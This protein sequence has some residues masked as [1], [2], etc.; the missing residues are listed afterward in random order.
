MDKLLENIPASDRVL[1]VDDETRLRELWRRALGDMGLCGAGARN[2]EEAVALARKMEFGVA[3]LDLNLPGC[4][5]L[6]LLD[7]LRA[8]QPDIAAVIVTGYGTLD[9]A[10]RAI[11]LDVVEFLTKPCSL[12]ELESAVDRARNRFRSRRPAEKASPL[13]QMSP[14]AAPAAATMS[15]V[16]RK[17][18]LES[19]ERNGGNRTETAR[20]LGIS[21]RTL[22]YRLSEYQREGFVV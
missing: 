1:V 3:M 15:E 17:A 21:V 11:H 16:E 12:G 14:A 2:A 6:D 19:L 4:D 22:Y 8:L 5:G 13:E 20:E 9:A 7:Q 10:K 18:I